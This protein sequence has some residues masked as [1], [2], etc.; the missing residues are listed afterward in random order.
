MG[1]CFEDREPHNINAFPA[2]IYSR[3][4][5]ELGE[6]AITK[7]RRAPALQNLCDLLP[8]IATSK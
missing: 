1:D 6:P 2:L 5:N 7:G 4:F 8:G 3:L